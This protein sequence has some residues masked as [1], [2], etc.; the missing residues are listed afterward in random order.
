MLSLIIQ[1]RSMQLAKTSFVS[2]IIILAKTDKNL[3]QVAEQCEQ[4]ITM[5]IV[6]TSRL[7]FN[8]HINVND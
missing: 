7:L 2:L 8:K 4:E 3:S 1:E 5:F 6:K